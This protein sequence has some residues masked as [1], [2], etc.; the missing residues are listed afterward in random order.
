[1]TPFLKHKNWSIK[2]D[3]NLKA[4]T[5]KIKKKQNESKRKKTNKYINKNI[6]IQI[7]NLAEKK[8]P[9]NMFTFRRELSYCIFIYGEVLQWLFVREKSVGHHFSTL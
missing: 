2:T 7:D 5:H 4:H 8:T 3:K 6:Q 9:K 1:M